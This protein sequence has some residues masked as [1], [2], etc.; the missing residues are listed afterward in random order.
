MAGYYFLRILLQKST[1]IDEDETLQMTIDLLILQS[2]SRGREIQG[3]KARWDEK[4]GPSYLKCAA[5]CIVV[6]TILRSCLRPASL[7]TAKFL[8]E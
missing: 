5:F 4:P 7:Y 8:T 3:K 1:L 2:K 6:E